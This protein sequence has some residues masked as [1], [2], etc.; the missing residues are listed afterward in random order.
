MARAVLF[1]TITPLAIRFGSVWSS[2]SQLDF[3]LAILEQGSPQLSGKTR[4]T[5]RCG[6]CTHLRTLSSLLQSC[7]PTHYW[8]FIFQQQFL[9]FTVSLRRSVNL[10]CFPCLL[11]PSHF[12]FYLSPS[13]FVFVVLGCSDWLTDG[14]RYVLLLTMILDVLNTILRAPLWNRLWT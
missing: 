5:L 4:F 1:T 8:L 2:I 11:S 3:R 7:V 14:L 12:A 6:L 10:F 13:L 9:T